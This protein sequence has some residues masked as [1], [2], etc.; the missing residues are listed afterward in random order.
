MDWDVGRALP[1]TFPS[2]IHYIIVII[3]ILMI[4][5]HVTISTAAHLRSFYWIIVKK[6]A[7]I[8]MLRVTL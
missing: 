7:V 2:Y 8:V 3:M 6:I 5:F 1:M 4:I